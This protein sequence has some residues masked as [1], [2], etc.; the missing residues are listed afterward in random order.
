MHLI[1]SERLIINRKY[2]GQNFKDTYVFLVANFFQNFKHLL[3]VNF[4]NDLELV[5][6]FS[7]KFV[8][9]LSSLLKLATTS[10]FE[11][12]SLLT[13]TTNLATRKTYV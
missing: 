5:A 6:N 4:S 9:E 7:L 10:V 12:R 11:L 2:W 8:I 3:V 13:L 1:Y